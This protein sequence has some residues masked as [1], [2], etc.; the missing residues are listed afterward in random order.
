MLIWAKYNPTSQRAQRAA[1]I[2]L[3]NRGDRIQAIKLLEQASKNIPAS[4]PIRIHLL[5]Y[6][7][8]ESSI[9]PKSYKRWLNVLE[10]L[11]YNFRAY[12]LVEKYISLITTNKCKGIGEKEA[13]LF[14]DILSRKAE[15]NKTPT[16]RRHISHLRGVLFAYEDKPNQSLE[17]FRQSLRIL[18]DVE[19]GL[20]GTA[21]LASHSHTAQALILLEYT[22]DILNYFGENHLKRTKDTYN[23]EIK[24]LR[25]K[26]L[27]DI[28]SNNLN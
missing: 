7:C 19:S 21:I 12:K 2:E 28:K 23:K 14:L 27:Q 20:L 15:Q 17:S 10:S 9:D 3:Y 8:L 18:P 24:I 25:E 1:A 4:V 6:K 11:Q 5:S 22:E 26:L 13:H 16:A